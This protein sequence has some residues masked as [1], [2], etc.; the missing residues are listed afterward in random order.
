MSSWCALLCILGV[1]VNDESVHGE[2]VSLKALGEDRSSDLL[3]PRGPSP[4]NALQARS[5]SASRLLDPFSRFALIAGETP[6][7]PANRLIG[8]LPKLSN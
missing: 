5:S 6:A 1:A 7:V 8:I 3:G 4:A 2:K